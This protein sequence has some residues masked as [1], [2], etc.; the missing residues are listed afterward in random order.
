MPG[1]DEIRSTW[2]HAAGWQAAGDEW[3]GPWGGSEPLWWGT[4]M[5]R[6]HAFLPAGRILELG[7]GQGRWSRYLKDRCDELVL[8]D[9]AEHALDACRERLAGAP[10]VSYHVGDGRS[11]GMVADASVDFAFSFDSLVHAE[12]D[13]MDAYAAELGRVLAP[14]GVAFLHHSNMAAH[15]RAA[16][17]ARRVPDA[18]RRRLTIHGVLVNVYA[19]R[20]ESTTAASFAAACARHGLVCPA[21]ELIAW[22]YGRRLTDVLSVV[23]RPGSRWDRPP[24][25]VR[26]PDFMAEARALARAAPLYATPDVSSST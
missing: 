13:V 18:L 10:N 4:L 11:L 22:E 12:T 25:R 21:Q 26:N 8:V 19:W 3:S 1:L 20:A 24:V 17:R 7:P 9:V 5:P 16:R 2:G 15:R 6:I 23:A 14:D